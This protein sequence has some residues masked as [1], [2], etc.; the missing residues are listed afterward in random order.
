MTMS[1]SVQQ[2]ETGA[3]ARPARIAQ[4]LT[5]GVN[6][7]LTRIR[8]RPDPATAAPRM[9]A[10]AIA[11]QQNESERLIGWVQLTLV[12]AFLVLFMMAP[13]LLP[14]SIFER[15]AFWAL[16]LYALF[17]VLRLYLSYRIRL[18]AWFLYLSI[19]ADMALL[20]TLIWSFHLEYQQ[21]APFY[22][23]APTLLYVFIFIAIRALRFE[24]RYVVVA[25]ITA[26]LGWIALLVYAIQ[27]GGGDMT[28]TRNYVTY[29]TSNS[30][31][32]GAEFD[33]I[34]SILTVTGILALA[35]YRG[36]NVLAVGA[37][38]HAAAEGLSRFFSPEIAN[39][40]KQSDNPIQAGEGEVRQAAI[41]MTDIRG[42]TTMAHDLEP[43][44]TV[45]LLGE[46]QAAMVPI[47]Q[48][49]GG[50]VDKFLGDGILATFGASQ[51]SETHAADALRA[52]M[53]CAVAAAEWGA[54]K[55]AEGTPEIRVG[56]A[57]AAGRVIF[58]AVGDESRLEYTVIGDP[59]NLAAKLEKHT[60][61]ESCR[62]LAT[63]YAFDAAVAQGFAPDGRQ[64]SLPAR[65][66]E[67]VED[68]QDIVKLA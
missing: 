46:Y 60:R 14:V 29:L 61:E 32:L 55:E 39:Q 63:Q 48:S 23:K 65:R 26:A 8:L 44:E 24:A 7:A 25:G 12:A 35:L 51:P 3:S 66:I 42:F 54:R 4:A 40:I 67:G 20:M 18:P 52:A 58:G 11:A 37:S 21:P 50:T 56:A 45:R 31:L 30:V 22:L 2:T 5:N 34:I 27:S 41:L 33:K 15:T 28:I 68:P 17:T 49:H 13:N 36:R 57:V 64:L 1:D 47:I 19:V 62:A 38:D 16:T 9:V 59:V 10:A 53:D 43:A 6:K